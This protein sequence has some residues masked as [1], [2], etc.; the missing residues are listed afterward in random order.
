MVDAA[1]VGNLALWQAIRDMGWLPMLLIG[2]GG[3]SILAILEQAVFYQPFE[4]VQIFQ[5]PLDGFHRLMM[6]L[7]AIVDPLIQPAID[8][9]NLRFAWSLTLDPVWRSI[10]AMMIVFLLA[11]V[12]SHWTVRRR[13][14][15][16]SFRFLVTGI[17]ALIGAL[18]AGLVSGDGGWWAQ[19]LRAAA[20]TTAF[21]VL[22]G[23]LAAGL[24]LASG[25]VRAQEAFFGTVAVGTVAVAVAAGL[26]LV[27]FGLAAGLSFVPWLAASAG[28]LTV[29]FSV[30]LIS[31]SLIYEGL[32]E[33]VPKRL[34]KKFAESDDPADERRQRQEEKQEE[35]EEKEDKR[36]SLRFGLTMLGGFVA[37]G[38]ILAADCVLK[39]LGVG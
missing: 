28:I 23:V 33:A 21:C 22:A 7:G 24:N 30:V 19:G 26:G 32:E 31:V 2:L 25:K 13:R 5:W 15:E 34:P 39:A 11:V 12:R 20:P 27:A 4:L 29:A 14:I 38:L 6:L 9:V 18:L 17:A 37:A 35:Q 36:A 3:F 8:W 16:V 1:K 10:F